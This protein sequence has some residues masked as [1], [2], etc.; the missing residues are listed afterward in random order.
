MTTDQDKKVAVGV[1]GG[2]DSSL[3]ISL[4]KKKGF[5][6]IGV[7]MK[8]W[9]DENHCCGMESE[10]RARKTC[11]DLEVPFYV[12]DVRDEF[13]KKVVDYF[14][15]SYGR[16]ETP[17]PCVVC[18]RD[19]KFKMLF[20]KVKNFGGSLVATG[21]YAKVEDGQLFIPKD[22][23][24]DQTYFLWSLQK[25]VLKNSLFPLGD[26]T[27]KEVRK[28]AKKIKL[29]A[30][31]ISDSQ[32][33]C[34]VED[35][36]ADFLERH[37]NFEPGDIESKEG[38]KLGAHKGLPVYTLGQRRGIGL[39]GGPFYVLGKDTK[40]N[41]LIVT[42]NE[43]DLMEKEVSF[44]DANFFEKTDFPVEVKAKIRYN[45]PKRKGVLKGKQEFFFNE[46]QRAIAS[47]QSI[48]FY[49]NN[50]LLGG[51]VIN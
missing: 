48:V 15:K 41:V 35:A 27:K 38:K 43:E 19:I 7:F 13:K 2:V 36:L 30:A 21:H 3:T 44:R 50:R 28:A 42:K 22:E 10:R 14:L 40:R 31:E 34:F 24:K 18:N 23:K 39:S 6:P 16:G 47:G 26:L 46:N 45:A 8:F 49:K 37:I 33:V 51:G 20:E 17:N 25:E 4:L 32:E 12:L 9:G 1:S 11:D 29:P 5:S